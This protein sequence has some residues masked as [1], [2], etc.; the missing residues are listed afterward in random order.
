M[1]SRH[2]DR[3]WLLGGVVLIVL[4]TVASWFLLIHPTYAQADERHGEAGDTQTQLTQ[5]RKKNSELA[6]EDAKLPQYQAKLDSYQEALTSGSG[7]PDFLRELQKIGD[8][9]GVPVSGLTIADATPVAGATNVESLAITL[10]AGGSPEDLSAF[11]TRLQNVQPRAL[12]IDS[13]NLSSNDKPN[14]MT[15]NLT[16]KAFVSG[17]ANEV[18][19]APSATTK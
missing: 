17:P 16:L 8:S 3:I 19:P 9:M 18:T 7:M 12:L 11:L 2:V 5:L 4:L 6:A 15:L 13:S 10:T 1:N 14:E